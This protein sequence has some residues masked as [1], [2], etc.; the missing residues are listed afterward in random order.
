MAL[1][2]IGSFLDSVRV[3]LG[4]CA[5]VVGAVPQAARASD[6]FERYRVAAV[7]LYEDLEYERALEQI[8][9][10]RKVAGS[11][12][13][14]VAA[15]LYEGIIL[16]DLAKEEESRAAFKTALLLEPEAKLPLA[17]A[18]KVERVFEELRE[19]V[20]EEVARTRALES[21]SDRPEQARGPKLESP[22]VKMREPFVPVAEREVR[23][24]VPVGPLVLA[25]T[26]V[27]AAGVGAWFGAK[28]RSTVEE[29]NSA[30]DGRFPPQSDL[31]RLDQT[32]EDARSQARTANVLFGVA[33]AAVGGAVLTWVLASSGEELA[34]QE[35]R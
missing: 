1:R 4:L 29:A 28:S 15:A 31:A 13:E 35:A 16:G 27:L 8:Q 9:R 26:G 24:D 23:R 5:L 2:T 34:T 21:P 17:V 6:D 22:E 7:R 32:L 19:S 20:R 10:A 30:Y 3:L 33:G 25:G 12:E 14:G 11:V 18:P